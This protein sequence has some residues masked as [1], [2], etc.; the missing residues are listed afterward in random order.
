MKDCTEIVFVLDESGS[1]DTIR[2][3][4][5]GGFNSFVADQK[6]LPGEAYLTLVKFSSYGNMQTVFEHVS[7]AE[8]KDLTFGSY[9]P[10]GMTAL[11]QAMHVTIDNVGK[12]LS[13]LT[14]DERPNKVIMVIMTD[15]EENNSGNKYSKKTISEKITHQSEV[16]KWEFL[17][18]GA[19]QDAIAEGASMG[20]DGA[21]SLTYQASARG[22]KAMYST[23]SNAVSSYRTTGDTG[24]L[25]EE[26]T[27]NLV[28]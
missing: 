17:F 14:E 27:K 24:N 26:Y 2:T 10:G 18:P 19:N 8:V 4:V 16:Y 20:I 28:D 25:T 21:K 1:M 11:L 12:R 6:A 23:I 3:D 9:T 7:I 5:I 22:T 15:G 13:D